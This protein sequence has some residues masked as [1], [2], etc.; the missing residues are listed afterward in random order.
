MSEVLQEK[1]R[2]AENV[3]EILG[4]LGIIETRRL[5]IFRPRL[6]SMKKMIPIL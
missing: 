2:D 3:G 6:E 5:L 4:N 1:V